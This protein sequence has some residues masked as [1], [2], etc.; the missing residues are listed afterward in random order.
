MHGLQRPPA[1]NVIWVL[2]EGRTMRKIAFIG[3][4][5]CILYVSLGLL[6]GLLP[7][8]LWSYILDF[9]VEREPNIFYKVVPAEGASY[10]I[11][12]VLFIGIVLIALSKIRSER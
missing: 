2:Y 11:F 3:G 4:V 7:V 6:I 1:L 5:L 8:N 12:F 10:Q 9:F